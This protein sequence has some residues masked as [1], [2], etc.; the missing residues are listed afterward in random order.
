MSI[1]ASSVTAVSF[2]HVYSELNTFEVVVK[3]IAINAAVYV[4]R[5]LLSFHKIIE[6]FHLTKIS[7]FSSNVNVCKISGFNFFFFFFW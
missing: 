3:R 4:V 7:F 5:I 6:V 2:T 1:S